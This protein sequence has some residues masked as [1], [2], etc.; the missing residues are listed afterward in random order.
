MTAMPQ[1]ET[2]QQAHEQQNSEANPFFTAET[3]DAEAMARWMLACQD[4]EAHES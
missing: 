3:S 4:D 2:R 1:N